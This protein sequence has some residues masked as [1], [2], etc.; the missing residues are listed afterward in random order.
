M[1]FVTFAIVLILAAGFTK[2][3]HANECAAE[4]SGLLSKPESS[5]MVVVNPVGHLNSPTE[6]VSE[7]MDGVDW[8]HLCSS[9]K[10]IQ[11]PES[12]S[13]CRREGSGTVCHRRK[14]ITEQRASD[15]FVAHSDEVITDFDYFGKKLAGC[16]GNATRDVSLNLFREAQIQYKFQTDHFGASLDL[17]VCKFQTQW[18][19]QISLT[20][21]GPADSGACDPDAVCIEPTF[22]LRS[23]VETPV[24]PRAAED[25]ERKIK[26]EWEA[27]KR[28]LEEGGSL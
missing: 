14:I 5:E 21:L 6:N 22:R 18:A 17:S 1:Q 4:F 28:W 27:R 20:V 11:S 24:H 2:P 15:R 23:G 16:F 3:A 8:E 10:A 26:E 19:S 7:A 9:L 25:E 13:N 12:I